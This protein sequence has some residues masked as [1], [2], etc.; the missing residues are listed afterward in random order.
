MSRNG[1]G[2]YSLAT[3]NPVVTGATISSTWANTTLS[4]IASA[5]TTSIASDGQTVISA[6]IPMNNNK[7][8][9]L[10]VPT[11]T[12]DALSYGNAATI[13][14]LTA[15]TINAT[16]TNSA[17]NGTLGATSPSTVVATSVTSPL[18]GSATTLQLQ[19]NGTTTAVTIDTAQN[20]GVGIT[21]SAW[22]PG[23]ISAFQVKLISLWSN[24]N[25]QGMGSNVYRGTSYTPY[26]ISTSFAGETGFNIQGN[27]EWSVSTAPS[28]TS[29][30]A[31]TLTERMRITTNGGL[32]YGGGS[33]YGTA[34]Q[35][36]QS[37]GDTTPTWV[38]GNLGVGQT[39]QT[40]TRASGT[41]YTNSTGRPIQISIVLNMFGTNQGSLVVNGLTVISAIVG[42]ASATQQFTFIIPNGNTYILTLSAGTIN[43]WLELR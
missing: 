5:L 11:I 31:C 22:N 4:D 14:T 38:G 8:T 24:N 27:G 40:V 16:T 28:G 36:L 25:S 34:G 7:I 35:V 30:A 18:Y 42:A 23:L 10:A 32:A 21:P 33:N 41:T 15:T 19:T 13:S 3:G 17:L 1:S 26:Y 12:G 6:N 39:W 2:I 43:S 20:V 29:G 9:G 37:N